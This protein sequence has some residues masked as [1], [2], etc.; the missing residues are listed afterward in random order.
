MAD[1]YETAHPKVTHLVAGS[2]RQRHKYY[3][4]RPN[5]TNDWLLVLT[6][7]GLGR[8]GFVG[9]EIFTHPGEL[10]LLKPGTLHDYGL[11][12]QKRSWELRW[13]HFHPRPHWIDWL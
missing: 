1:R 9:G 6:L 11:E 5:G 12:S 4:W 2:F 3:A 13:T 7:T 10:M 8:F